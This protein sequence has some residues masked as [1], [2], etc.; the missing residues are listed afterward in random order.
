[1]QIEVR[2]S[3]HLNF[4][5]NDCMQKIWIYRGGGNYLVVLHRVRTFVPPARLKAIHLFLKLLKL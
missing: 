2:I 5:G 1:M 4:S 3:T